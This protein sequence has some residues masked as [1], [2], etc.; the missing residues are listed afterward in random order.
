[1]PASS[2]L[3]ASL[4]SSPLTSTYLCCR[5]LPWK[6]FLTTVNE[7]KAIMHLPHRQPHLR[8]SHPRSLALSFSFSHLL[9]IYLPIETAQGQELLVW[10]SW[11]SISD[12]VTR[13]QVW[14]PDLSPRT[15]ILENK[16]QLMAVVF[17]PHIPQP[18]I[19]K[20]NF[21]KWVF[22]S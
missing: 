2:L 22:A 10:A 11:P 16:S 1:M 17:S 6:S 12:K 13:R 21:L 3:S 18:Q 8:S 9:I 15:P 4:Y 5:L 14:Q 20:C 7:L 19:N